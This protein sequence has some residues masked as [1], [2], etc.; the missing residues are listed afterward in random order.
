M[1]TAPPENP[2]WVELATKFIGAGL[3]LPPIPP[4]LRAQ[5]QPYGGWCWSTRPI[6]SMEMYLFLDFRPGGRTYLIDVL[7]D[8][9]EDYAAVSHAGHGINSFAINFH[10]VHGPLAVVMQVAW[11]G[12]YMDNEEA[13]LRLSGYW[14]QVEEMLETR[15]GPR[16]PSQQRMTVVYSDFRPFWGC[17]WAARPMTKDYDLRLGRSAPQYGP[18]DRAVRLWSRPDLG[19][20]EPAPNP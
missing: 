8:R 6:D 17:G 9:V 5:L 16:S 19:T 20:I 10:L 1:T 18:F 12:V 2:S 13:A 15:P 4:V 11:G 7:Q 3:P 14:S